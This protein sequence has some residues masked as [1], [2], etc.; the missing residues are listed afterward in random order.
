M[1]F[2][3]EM[4]LLAVELLESFGMP[5]R[6]VRETGGVSDPVAGTVT[7]AMQNEATPNA[8]FTVLDD[9]MVQRAGDNLRS[10]DRMLIVA[11]TFEPKNGDTIYDHD[12]NPWEAVRCRP[13]K[14]TDLLLAT[15]VQCRL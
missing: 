1:S 5:V 13:I 15:K 4:R 7:G 9:E 3:Q 14:P 12:G 6:I 8:V 10:S 2:Y 11:P